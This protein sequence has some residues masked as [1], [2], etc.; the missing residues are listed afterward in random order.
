MLVLGSLMASAVALV[1]A[2]AS[3]DAVVLVCL[4]VASAAFCW[5]AAVDLRSGRIPNSLVLLAAL[6]GAVACDAANSGAGPAVAG[7]AMA[8]IPLL[9]IHLLDPNAL[10]FGDVKLAAAGGLVVAAISWPAAIVVPLLALGVALG[11]RLVRPV[12][13][14]AFGPSLVFA[15]AGALVAAGFMTVNGVGT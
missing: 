14:R 9:L 6:A 8:A 15:T 1:E 12:G 11:D 3:P 5:A 13:P 10:G 7:A 2:T 4:G